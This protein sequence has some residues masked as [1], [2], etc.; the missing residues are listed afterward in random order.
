MRQ[1]MVGGNRA[2]VV[3]PASGKMPC[4]AIACTGRGCE[5]GTGGLPNLAP[6][7]DLANAP[8]M[9]RPRRWAIDITRSAEIRPPATPMAR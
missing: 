7:V 1:E 5:L 9:P 4:R 8:Q 3:A 6:E 2:P